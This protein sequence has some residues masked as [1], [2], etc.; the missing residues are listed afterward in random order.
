MY[1]C[2]AIEL[3]SPMQTV[4]RFQRFPSSNATTT[5]N[6]SLPQPF[7]KKSSTRPT[8]QRGMAA[9][10]PSHTPPP[11]DPLST[12]AVMTDDQKTN[13]MLSSHPH[14]ATKTTGTTSTAKRHPT[15]NVGVN[16][17]HNRPFVSKDEG[18]MPQIYM[19]SSSLPPQR[20][21]RGPVREETLARDTSDT[22]DGKIP[23]S[24]QTVAEAVEDSQR[25]QELNR[26]SVT[27]TAATTHRGGRTQRQGSL[28]NST[29]ASSSSY[30]TRPPPVTSHTQRQ[31]PLSNSTV[32]SSSSYS[33]RPPPVTSHTQRQG[34]LSNSTFASSSSYSTRPP[35]V[36]SH[37]Q[38]QGPLSNSTFASSSSS[39][40]PP[41]VSYYHPHS[42]QDPPPTRLIGT[43]S[44]VV[45]P[46]RSDFLSLQS[47]RHQPMVPTPIPIQRD[48]M[49]NPLKMA[50]T[51]PSA[52]GNISVIPPISS[53]RSSSTKEDSKS[54]QQQD[55]T[56]Y[57]VQVN[58][59]LSDKGSTKMMTDTLIRKPM[60][61]L[62][63]QVVPIVSQNTVAPPFKDHSSSSSSSS[64]LKE[65]KT[66]LKTKQMKISELSKGKGGKGVLDAIKITPAPNLP[67]EIMGSKPYSS[68][69]KRSHKDYEVT[70][71]PT[72]SS[73]ENISPLSINSTDVSPANNAEYPPPPFPR[74]HPS[75][76]S[77]R[78]T[79]SP[80]LSRS[81]S[82]S[83]D[84]GGG[85][86]GSERS[87]VLVSSSGPLVE[88]TNSYTDDYH[89][90]TTGISDDSVQ[91]RW[92]SAYTHHHG[93]SQ[94]MPELEAV[95]EVTQTTPRQGSNPLVRASSV[96]A[97]AVRVSSLA[98]PSDRSAAN[99]SRATGQ[100]SGSVGGGGR[101]KGASLPHISS[102]T[103]GRK[104]AESILSPSSHHQTSP[105]NFATGVQ[106]NGRHTSRP[107]GISRESDS[108]VPG[109]HNFPRGR[110]Q[111]LRQTGPNSVKQAGLSVNGVHLQTNRHTTG[112]SS[113]PT[114]S[115]ET[116]IEQGA[117]WSGRK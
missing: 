51:R 38:R 60:A 78:E 91:S 110:A 96:P 33:T 64:S 93:N 54:L 9:V 56:F 84:G 40:W 114:K 30:S 10:F 69:M 75:T 79:D 102:Q 32:A 5:T 58:D 36:T 99:K 4:C 85:S 18:Q 14:S 86:G 55:K 25:S 116:T 26:S 108:R 16:G 21:E 74:R 41:P 46:T 11:S 20:V 45:R 44:T 88:Y 47:Q 76:G 43:D 95:P 104:Q 27:D 37:T 53:T 28:S 29:V 100:S 80:P 13:L 61:G 87:A 117:E 73:S 66:P 94:A 48:H 68:E 6:S 67:L 71:S 3:Y 17:L 12:S 22:R 112:G 72:A 59:A 7:A 65:T 101:V 19:H 115:G 52:V 15:Q 111:Y 103:R 2:I 89:V 92:S 34:P 105:V 42:S 62:D 50:A 24:P 49:S 57:N 23:L 39:T 8:Q 113:R 106:A 98:K 1:I 82:Y 107:A 81:G 35:P 63:L 83:E 90:H 70:R 109:K 31:G 97:S 77:S